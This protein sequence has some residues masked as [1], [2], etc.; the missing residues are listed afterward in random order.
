MKWVIWKNRNVI[1]YQGKLVTSERLVNFA[2]SEL[3]LLLQSIPAEKAGN[4]NYI[5]EIRQSLNSII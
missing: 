3:N 5:N 4:A 1:K 2:K